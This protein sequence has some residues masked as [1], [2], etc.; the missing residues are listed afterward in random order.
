MNTISLVNFAEQI[1]KNMNAHLDPSSS[2]LLPVYS[3]ELGAW[4]RREHALLDS[5]ALNAISPL[6]RAKAGDIELPVAPGITFEFL[7]AP[8]TARGFFFAGGSLVAIMAA[9]WCPSKDSDL[10]WAWILACCGCALPS[11]LK[12]RRASEFVWA[13]MTAVDSVTKLEPA[14]MFV[15]QAFACHLASRLPHWVTTRN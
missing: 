13:A 12:R 8:T 10:A 6:L 7:F 3:V 4:C 5:G 9:A 11:D 2:R 1:D 15:I 14:T